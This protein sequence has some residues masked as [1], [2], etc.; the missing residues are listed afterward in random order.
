MGIVNNRTEVA[1]EF[2][3]PHVASWLL[4]SSPAKSLPLACTRPPLQYFLGDHI[5]S[6]LL[7]NRPGH[8]TA[9]G[10]CGLKSRFTG[11]SITPSIHNFGMSQLTK[12]FAFFKNRWD[13]YSKRDLLAS[14][15]DD[16]FFKNY[17]YCYFLMDHGNKVRTG[18][19]NLLGITWRGL[20]CWSIA[21]RQQKTL[22]NFYLS[23]PDL[24]E[25]WGITSQHWHP[26]SQSLL[27]YICGFCSNLYSFPLSVWKFIFTCI[28]SSVWN[29]VFL[30][31]KLFIDLNL[32]SF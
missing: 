17:Y 27:L 30:T 19:K 2:R 13:L 22:L 31:S 28:S 7:S 11:R 4:T 3:P 23:F 1:L 6:V 32:F 9:G 21:K 5:L 26:G 12:P 20:K 8:L 29:F 15:L 24:T 14:F 10:K 16:R 18:R 25:T